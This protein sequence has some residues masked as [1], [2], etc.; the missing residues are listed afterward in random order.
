MLSILVKL[1]P[2]EGEMKFT[3]FEMTELFGFVKFGLHICE[4][5][6]LRVNKFIYD[7]TLYQKGN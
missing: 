2:L 6:E 7:E 3:G 5:Q 4:L 1:F